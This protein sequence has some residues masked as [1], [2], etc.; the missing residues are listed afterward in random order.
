[1]KKFNCPACGAENMFRSA[2]SLYIVCPYCHCS[3]FKT[4]DELAVLG[5][6]SQ[7]ADDNSPLQMRSEGVYQNTIYSVVGRVRMKWADGFWNE[8]CLFFKD[9]TTGWLAEAQGEFLIT[10]EITNTASVLASDKW[11]LNK[12]IALDGFDFVICDLKRAEVFFS[13]GELPFRAHLGDKRYSADLRLESGFM[14][15]SLE[16]DEDSKKIRAYLGRS[17][18]LTDLKMTYLRTF[19]DW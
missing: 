7:L 1:M 10:K 14:F 2:L 19:N 8:W 3:L 4:D 17:T 12:S 13:E 16:Q 6:I 5:K 15:G 11:E 18:E 9:G